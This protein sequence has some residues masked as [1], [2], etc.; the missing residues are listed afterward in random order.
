MYIIY[1]QTRSLCV[2]QYIRLRNTDCKDMI[3]W[4]KDT[5]TVKFYVAWKYSKSNIKKVWSNLTRILPVN[6]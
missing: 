3:K 5:V 2:L 4:L 6:I 1:K